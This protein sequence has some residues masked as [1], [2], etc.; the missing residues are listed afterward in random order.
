VSTNQS[1]HPKPPPANSIP[2]PNFT[3]HI[4]SLPNTFATPPDNADHSGYYNS[5]R[6]GS[7]SNSGR[8]KAV[9]IGILIFCAFFAYRRWHGSSAMA[10]WQDNWEKGVD[11]SL[12]NK[13][14]QLVLF[15]ADWCPA[16]NQLEENVLSQ[17]EVTDKLKESF[18]LT[19]IDLTERGG[20]N[21]QIARDFGVSVIPTMYIVGPDGARSTPLV[22]S[23]PFERLTQWINSA[24][25]IKPATH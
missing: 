25:L 16:C 12:S 14:P 17:K 8:L 19:K 5:L 1:N 7:R 2:S 4:P 21:N 24:K 9:F 13:K 18:I 15:T 3:T 22:G 23:V 10:A 6:G 11:Q 20:P